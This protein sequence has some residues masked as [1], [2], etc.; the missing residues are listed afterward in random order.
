MKFIKIF[1]STLEWFQAKPFK[2]VILIDVK[3]PHRNWHP[4]DDKY[5]NSDLHFMRLG[6]SCF[7][8]P[9]LTVSL[10]FGTSSHLSNF[11]PKE[12]IH[13]QQHNNS[14]SNENHHHSIS[15]NH[16]INY[17]NTT[18]FFF[19]ISPTRRDVRAAIQFIIDNPRD[20]TAPTK[21]PTVLFQGKLLYSSSSSFLLSFLF[22]KVAPLKPVGHTLENT[23]TWK[24]TAKQTLTHTHS[25][26]LCFSSFAAKE[27]G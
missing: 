8:L 25:H 27:K 6:Q 15:P 17:D 20:S 24:R 10:F 22:S 3:Y 26:T 5:A 4:R 13:H 9:M 19:R 12:S 7:L 21:L 14:L 18:L 23:H 16:S 1:I 2:R 11:P